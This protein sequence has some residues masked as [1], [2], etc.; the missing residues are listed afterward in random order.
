LAVGAGQ[1][2]RSDDGG[3]SWREIAL[4]A[5]ADLSFAVGDS[6]RPAHV[7]PGQLAVDPNNHD[8]LYVRAGG[9]QKSVDGGSSWTPLSVEGTVVAVAVSPADA[10]YVHAVTSVA[11]TWQRIMSRDG[12]L[13]WEQIASFT[14]TPV[15]GRPGMDYSVY[16]L[17]PHPTDP[18]R[19][20]IAA[21]GTTGRSTQVG[22]Y[23]SSDGDNPPP[24]VALLKVDPGYF[25]DAEHLVGGAGAAP[26]RYYAA[27]NRRVSPYSQTSTAKL[28]RVEMG[29]GQ[30]VVMQ[31][32]GGGGVSGKA[33]G[34]V[35]APAVFIDALAYDP[36]T[37]DRVYAGL[38]EYQVVVQPD[39]RGVQLARTRSHVV[40]STDGGATWTDLGRADLGS[41][42]RDLALGIDGANLY[43]GTEGGV[44]RLPMAR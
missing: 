9:L 1:L 40:A 38:N 10:S 30:S 6:Y 19:V 37:P 11:R 18:E 25:I 44:F 35:L 13:T 8:I 22:L 29:G 5:G 15:S 2:R 14:D 3:A 7:G 42:I 12:G 21:G 41:E 33:P 17:Q 32:E 23:D 26:G 43:A 31:V 16:L 24:G 34:D 28:M 39:G 27:F 4:P 20:F 36:S